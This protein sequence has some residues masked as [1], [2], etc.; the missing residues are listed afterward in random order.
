MLRIHPRNP[1][2][3]P[4]SDYSD[5]AKQFL[6]EYKKTTNLSEHQDIIKNF[7][8]EYERA[9]Q[10]INTFWAESYRDQSFYLGNQWSLE[11]LSYLS[12]QRRSSFTYNMCRRMISLIEGI[13]R[14]NRLS[15]VYTPIEDA[16]SQTADLM[17]DVGQYVMQSGGGYETIST[18]FKD[19]CVAGISWI[20]PY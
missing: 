1:M 7:G 2:A 3:N 15:T 13:Q 11:E 17:S 4:Q 19:A 8:E 10:Q 14:S 5:D 6:Q 20:S 9:Y 18:A 12:N 16:S